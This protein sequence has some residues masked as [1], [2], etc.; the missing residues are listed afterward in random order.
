MLH[1]KFRGNRPT[2]SGDEDFL[3][4]IGV[5]AIFGPCEQNY[6]GTTRRGSV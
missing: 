5:A 3:P 1:T 6:N 2:V 4:Y